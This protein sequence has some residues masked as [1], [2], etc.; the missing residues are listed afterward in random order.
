MGPRGLWAHVQV[1]MCVCALSMSTC[2]FIPSPSPA[3][4]KGC[5][6]LRDEPG[7]PCGERHRGIIWA[8]GEILRLEQGGSF[9]WAFGEHWLQA[10]HGLTVQ[11]MVEEGVPESVISVFAW[12]SSLLWGVHLVSPCPVLMCE[13]T[14][15]PVYASP[16]H[17]GGQRSL[18]LRRGLGRN[19]EGLGRNPQGPMGLEQER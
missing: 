11:V 13:H 18:S 6:G 12:I 10:L 16:A 19:R 17:R 8:L 9:L 5:G 1:S 3:A 15:V 4:Q 14:R 7:V 2:P